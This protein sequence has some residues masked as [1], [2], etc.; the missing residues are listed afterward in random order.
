MTIKIFVFLLCFSF[1]S[2]ASEVLLKEKK[3]IQ[4]HLNNCKIEEA[5]R[6]NII[7]KLYKDIKIADSRLK[8]IVEKENIN[9]SKTKSRFQICRKSLLDC[10]VSKSNLE[11]YNKILKK[12]LEEVD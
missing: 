9:L 11:S 6:D 12:T 3:L 2:C 4:I 10:K 5:A 7:N 8:S 1:F